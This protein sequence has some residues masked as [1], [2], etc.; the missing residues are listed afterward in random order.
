MRKFSAPN[1]THGTPGTA[2]KVQVLPPP[3]DTTGPRRSLPQSL[4]R[5]PYPF[6]NESARHKDLSHMTEGLR[7]PKTPTSSTESV[8]VLSIRPS[9]TN[10]R[11][12]VTSMVIPASTT[13]STIQT[14]GSNEKDNHP[15]SLDFDDQEFFRQLQQAYSSLAGPW[16]FFSARSLKRIVVSGSASKAADAGYGWLHQPR[17]PRELAFKGLKDTFGEDTILAHYYRP[18]MGKSRYAFVQWAHRLA[19][20]ES[21]QTPLKEHERMEVEGNLVRRI[22]QPEGLEFVLSW[23][24]LRLSLALL[25]VLVA[26]IA[27]VFLWTFL[28][29]NTAL[30]NLDPSRS[31]DMALKHP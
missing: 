2:K 16:R 8:L 23:S 28:G 11:R 13:Y 7:T 9:T 24:I 17:S 4:I 14:A 21:V 22:E 12:R 30:A 15:R 27:A 1:D 29:R 26:S 19:A 25:L 18:A 5:T 10:G 31:S 3:I 20:A 6:E